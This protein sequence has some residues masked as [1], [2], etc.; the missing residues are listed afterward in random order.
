MLKFD[1]PQ[2]TRIAPSPTGNAHIGFVR[3]AYLNY[4]AARSSG[5]KFILRIDDTDKERSKKEYEDNILQ[6]M[7]WLGLE[8]D[9]IHHQSDRYG[10]Y[11]EVAEQLTNERV[12]R[13]QGGAT[14]LNVGGYRPSWHDLIQGEVMLRDDDEKLMSSIQNLVLCRADGSPT[15]HFASC[16][17]D[18]D[19]GVNLIIR[20]T[21]HF[22]NTH[23]HNQILAELECIE[24]FFSNAT[25]AIENGTFRR[26]EFAHVGLIF[27]NGKK[28]SKR[29]GLSSMEYYKERYTPE[30]VLNAVL[31]LG[32]SHPD[33]TFDKRYPLVDKQMAIELFPEGQLKAVKS[34]LDTGKLDWLNKRYAK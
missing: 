13:K 25:K 29:D 32:W 23:K 15:Y 17:D 22:T 9:E 12:T 8:Y 27:H 14:F 33:P 34:T 10:R 11:Q 28:I 31:K 7:E 21:D 18:M 3:T 5:G 6:T 19:M 16:I 4:L 1:V 26:M 2:N 24:P 30:A 20:G